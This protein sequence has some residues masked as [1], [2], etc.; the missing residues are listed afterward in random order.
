MSQGNPGPPSD[1]KC[2]HCLALNDL[3]A[4]ECWLCS[5]R[6]WRGAPIGRPSHPD[7]T[8]PRRGWLATI[9]GLPG[10]SGWLVLILVIGLSSAL[11]G[12]RMIGPILLILLVLVLVIASIALAAV[13][14]KERMIGPVPL[15]LMVLIV[16][17][18]ALMYIVCR[19]FAS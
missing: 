4:P 9:A 12:R 2:R 1:S 7:S 14:E 13:V 6:D 19:A 16:V 18:T 8:R 10:L 11:E 3:D 17:V 15:I 5:R